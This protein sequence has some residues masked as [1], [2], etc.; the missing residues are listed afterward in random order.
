MI[1]KTLTAAVLAS[2]TALTALPAAAGGS[3]SFTVNAANPDEARAIRAGLTLYQ[4][5]R[6][7]ESGAFVNQDGSYNG[8][9][10]R[11]VAGGGSVGIIHQEG[12]GHAATLDQQGYGQSHGIFQFG[13][14]ANANVV[15]TYHGQAGLT[16]Q[17]GFD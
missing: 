16:F 5:A 2:A 13:N 9:A 12:N 3:L 10:I 6:G 4:I 1:R 15:Q 8:A 7:V 11:Q 17:F 14:G